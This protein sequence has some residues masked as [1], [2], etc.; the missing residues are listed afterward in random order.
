MFAKYVK[1]LV[2]DGYFFREKIDFIL[3]LLYN[4]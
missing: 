3:V 2:F 1:I 4:V